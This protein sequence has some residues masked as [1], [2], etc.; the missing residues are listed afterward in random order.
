MTESAI[1]DGA[2]GFPL[3]GELPPRRRIFTNRNLRM[4]SIAAIGFDM[5]HTLASTTSRTSAASA[6]TWRSS[7]SCAI[8]T[9]RP[10]SWMCHG[11]PTPPSAAWSWT[12]SWAT[13]S[14]S[15]GTAT[16]RARGTAASSSIATSAVAPIRGAA[17]ASVRRAIACSIRCSTCRR[18]ASTPRWSTRWRAASFRCASR[19]DG[20]TT[21]SA[22]RSTPCMPTARSR[23]ASRPTSVPTSSTTPTWCR[24]SNGSVPPAS[25][26]SS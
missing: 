6:S 12:R 25:A 4:E 16:S 18:A 1:D 7:A 14:R 15:T 10:R 5:D 11:C 3:P 2:E 9:T 23:P 22:T 17:R 24:R 21:T 8:A 20:C 19:S 13:C 26:C